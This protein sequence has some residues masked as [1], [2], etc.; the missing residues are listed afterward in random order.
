MTNQLKDSSINGEYV[1][2]FD[3]IPRFWQYLQGLKSG[4]LVT[5]LIQ[6]ELDAESYHTTITFHADK[7]TCQG[8]G[9]PV[10]DEGWTRLSF[11][12]GAGNLAPRKR[13]R[14]GIKNHGL[15][16][17]FMIGDDIY[18]RSD[19]KF[20]RQTL[21]R[22]GVHQPPAPGALPK[23]H[24][25]NTAPKRG[26]LVELPYRHQILS[27]NVG[28]PY[29]LPAA[30]DELVDSLFLKAYQEMPQRFIGALR[31]HKRQHY[32]VDL[33]HHRLG[34]IRFKFHCGRERPFHNGKIYNRTCQI[35]GSIPDLSHAYHEGCYLHTVPL[36]KTTNKE[37]PEFYSLSKGRFFTEIAWHTDSHNKP[38]VMLGRRRYPIAYG[39]SDQSALTGVGFHFSGPY[40]S[41]LERHGASDAFIFNN[42][43]DE[44]CKTMMVN[45][46]RHKLIPQYGARVMNLLI[47]DSDN[48]DENSLRNLVERILEAGAF[49]LSQRAFKKRG[50]T[51]HST[52]RRKRR[53]TLFGPTGT[54]EGKIHRLVLPIFKWDLDKVSPLLAKLCPAHQNQIDPEVPGPILKLLATEGCKGWL[55]NH[56]RFDEDDIVERLQPTREANYF[57]WPDEESWKATLGDP[58]TAY[59]YLDVI[60]EIY[61]NNREYDKDKLEDLV[62]YAFLPNTKSIASPLKELYA[63]VNLPTGLPIRN[64]PQILHPKVGGHSIFRRDIWKR[65]RFTFDQFLDRARIESA[66]EDTRKLFWSWIKANWRKVTEKQLKRLTGLPIWPTNSGAPVPLSKLCKPHKERVSVI[67]KDVLCV[68]DPQI[69]KIGPVRKAKRG[70]LHIHAIPSEAEFVD[71]VRTRIS[72]FSCQLPLS[73]DEQRNFH[74]F[75][76]QL[77]ELAKD[78]TLRLYFESLSEIAI[79][80]DSQ[81]MLHPIGNLI[82]RNKSIEKLYLL[83]EDILDRPPGILDRVNGWK[84]K[85]FPSS[86]QVLKALIKDA[87]RI[88]AYLPRLLAYAQAAKSEQKYPIDKDVINVA[89][90]PYGDKVYAPGNLAFTNARGDYW[91][92]W[93]FRISGKELSAD[94][95]NVYRS[96]GVLGKD[97]TS[98]SSLAYFQWLK[99]Q[100]SKTVAANMASIIRHINHKSGPS[101]WS[102][103]NP[104]CPFIPVE[105]PDGGI[106]L[107]SQSVAVS[108]RSLIFISDFE[109]LATAIRTIPDRQVVRLVILGHPTVREPITSFLQE[110]RV[111]SLRNYAGDPIGVEGNAISETPKNILD[112]LEKLRTRKMS[113]ELRKR[114]DEL[115]VNTHVYKLRDQW[116][117]RL[118]QIRNVTVAASIKA[119]FQIGRYR[120]TIPM[121]TAFD[122]SNG[123][124]WLSDSDNLEDLF[125]RAVTERIFDNPPKFLPLVVK[126]AVHREFIE[127]YTYSTPTG[128][129]DDEGS[130]EGE[131][132]GEDNSGGEPGGT[133][134]THQGEPPD[135]RKNL[136]K[137]E[138]LPT[139]I[140]RK[141]SSGRSP[142]GKSPTRE[143]SRV[144]EIQIENLKKNQYAW[145]CQICLTERPPEQLAPVNSYVE[146]QENRSELIKAHHPDQVNAGGARHAG[147]IL[148]LC[149]YHHRYFGDAVTRND[150]IHALNDTATD[151][152]VVFGT[153]IDG[154]LTQKVV[155]GKLIIIQVPL[156]GKTVKC[157]FTD[158]HAKYWL[159]KASK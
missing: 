143:P 129:L 58:G 68:P 113:Q 150:I 8:N 14:I 40:I 70:I 95:Q 10:D 103:E 155:H 131:G 57:P 22:N 130:N 145:H 12:M 132:E 21:Y 33:I 154:N 122:E 140:G 119:T 20:I 97:P 75:E 25:D 85:A 32:I 105:A 114:I 139:G 16:V 6:N 91:G 118:A 41:D 1:Q 107:V 133:P 2:W 84:P 121:D 151:Y 19:G 93:K 102:D 43:I 135:P 26:C 4:N 99:G 124:I 136:P 115:E 35:S 89:C 90:I 11:I 116:R 37:I 51:K 142:G 153:F 63:G 104:N 18:I 73:T 24:P 5:E 98:E 67:L 159:Q 31:P 71:F 117:D 74:T 111:K 47:A 46:L 29:E 36:P 55:E 3:D 109:A 7:L 158:E 76:R 23:P 30:S 147:N 66:D 82:R 53:A 27:V 64:M 126:E 106:Q 92:T 101:S 86:D 156:T 94:I 148:I 34:T 15:K 157:F 87:R 123:T 44:A 125:Y 112:E 100:N 134:Q 128:V 61:K 48:P 42:Q 80:L 110:L 65:P 28:E 149:N 152:E 120:Y 127:N 62:N 39:G 9:K 45:I 83:E 38:L 78:R 146:I 59:D 96:V 54:T 141:D 88:G 138:S 144:E 69:F 137:P 108:P 13:K 17:C 79:G 50:G 77:V 60:T 72:E 49:P 56:I 52:S 81:G